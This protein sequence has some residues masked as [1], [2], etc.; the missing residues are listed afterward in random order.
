MKAAH[1]EQHIWAVQ[2]MAASGG[3]PGGQIFRIVR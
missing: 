3:I 1:D 2:N